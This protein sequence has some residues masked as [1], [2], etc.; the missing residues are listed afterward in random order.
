MQ[1][2]TETIADLPIVGQGEW[3]ICIESNG[4]DAG[5]TYHFRFVLSDG[6]P[7]DAYIEYPTLI[8]AMPP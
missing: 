3:D 8:T 5:G 2:A 7:L 4:V 1:K 6:T